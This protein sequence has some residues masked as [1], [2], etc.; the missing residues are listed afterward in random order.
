M[1]TYTLTPEPTVYQGFLNISIIYFFCIYVVRG[2]HLGVISLLI[3]CG[4]QEFNRCVRVGSKCLYPLSVLPSPEQMLFKI[5]YII[6]KVHG[7]Y[8]H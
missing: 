7:A 2:Q 1:C 5:T 6:Y 3:P 8:S 4:S